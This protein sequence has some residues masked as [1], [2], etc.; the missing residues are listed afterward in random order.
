MSSR[1]AL[2]VVESECS[3]SLRDAVRQAF[4]AATVVGTVAEA[5]GRI[6]D[7]EYDFV[8]SGVR[9]PDGNWAEVLAYLVRSGR[10]ADFL[11]CTSVEDE[12][13]EAQVLARGGAGVVSRPENVRG[14]AG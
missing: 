13:L 6:R 14:L 4:P 3:P 1:K 7:A 8:L 9:L 2:L 11:L 10:N 12:R 5:R